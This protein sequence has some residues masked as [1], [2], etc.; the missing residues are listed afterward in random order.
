MNLFIQNTIYN[1]Y[2]NLPS[3][4]SIHSNA[5]ALTRYYA[6]VQ[7]CNMDPIVEPEDLMECDNSAKECYEKTS[8][9]NKQC[10]EELIVNKVN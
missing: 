7:E 8:E 10:F 6:L 9:V 1:I 5:H 4:I 3:K 2:K